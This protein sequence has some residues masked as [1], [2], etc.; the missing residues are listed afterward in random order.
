MKVHLQTSANQGGNWKAQNAVD[1]N[2]L[3]VFSAC[4]MGV[5]R[6]AITVICDILNMPLPCQ[7]KAWHDHS[8]ALCNAHK[9][10]VDGKLA[11]A[12]AHVQNCAEKKPR[13]G[14]G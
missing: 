6:D 8:Q 2:R 4:E 12:R 11:R 13:P 7:T 5:G 9:E 1:I 3:V 14:C 10:A